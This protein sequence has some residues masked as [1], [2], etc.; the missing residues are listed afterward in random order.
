MLDYFSR[1]VSQVW[2]I[3]FRKYKHNVLFIIVS[4][5]TKHFRYIL[6]NIISVFEFGVL[7]SHLEKKSEFREVK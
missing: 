5:F 7:T 1:A 6:K 4:D 3:V 2:I